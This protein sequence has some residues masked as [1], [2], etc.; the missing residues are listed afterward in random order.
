L[1]T[2]IK[3]LR[4][5]LI[6]CPKLWY[7]FP[8]AVLGFVLR[9]LCLLGKQLNYIPNPLYFNHF[10]RYGL[11]LFVWASLRLWSFFLCLTIAGMTD[12]HCHAQLVSWAGASVNFVVQGGLKL[13]SWHP[14]PKY[15][16]LQAW[17]AIL[18]PIY[19]F[20]TFMDQFLMSYIPHSC[21][22]ILSLTGYIL[23]GYVWKFLSKKEKWSV[24]SKCL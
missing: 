24:L 23:H 22:E 4:I 2:I 21:A 3:I 10:F 13:Q 1:V 15:P 9:T 5:K 20:N 12:V 19:N 16:G 7:I 11:M 6:L 8:L 17:V 14:P 18:N